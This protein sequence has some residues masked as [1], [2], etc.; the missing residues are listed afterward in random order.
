MRSS[1]P[2]V[3][4]LERRSNRDQWAFDI[5]KHKIPEGTSYEFK[6]THIL[7]EPN[8]TH[9]MGLAL[10]HWRPVPAGRHPELVPP[11]TDPTSPLVVKNMTLME[12][13][14]YLTDE[15][16]AEDHRN[17]LEPVNT[18]RQKLGEKV[19][20]AGGIQINKLHR[21]MERSEIPD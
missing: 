21:S 15:A 3:D 2:V 17:A 19:V 18:M 1:A 10:D 13:P 9:M 8:T 16:R 5:P 12:R 6:A 11:G 14:Q 4:R 7:N 20:D